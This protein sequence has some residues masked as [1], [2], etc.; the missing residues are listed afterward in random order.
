MNTIVAYNVI[1]AIFN[2]I[3]GR[4][5]NRVLKPKFRFLWRLMWIIL[6]TKYVL[7]PFFAWWNGIVRMLNCIIWG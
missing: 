4:F 5:G 3:Y 7:F 1:N 2:L 6:F